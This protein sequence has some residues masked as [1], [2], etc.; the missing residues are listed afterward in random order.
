MGGRISS[1]TP[2]Y[3]DGKAMNRSRIGFTPSAEC[4]WL[5]EVECFHSDIV[6]HFHGYR[7]VGHRSLKGWIKVCVQMRPHR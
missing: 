7:P 2:A 6:I 3:G 4:P 1:G 5:E